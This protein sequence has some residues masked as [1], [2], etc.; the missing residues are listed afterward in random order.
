MD[1]ETK[2]EL[3]S[4]EQGMKAEIGRLEKIIFGNGSDGMIGR[5][6]RIEDRQKNILRVA[7][8]VITAILLQFSSQILTIISP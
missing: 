8:I 1:Q 3:K 6:S 2:Q 7:W 4:L 5:L